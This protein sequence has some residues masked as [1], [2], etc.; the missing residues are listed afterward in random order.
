MSVETNQ[1]YTARCITTQTIPCIFV[2]H[3]RVS[4]RSK[5]S[6]NYMFIS[7]EHSEGRN[8]NIDI[9]NKSFE[10]VEHFKYFGKFLT[11]ENNFHIE[12]SGNAC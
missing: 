8:C 11:N 12:N 3:T 5:C 6:E 9:G 2:Y 4:S 1:N 7:Q 10:R